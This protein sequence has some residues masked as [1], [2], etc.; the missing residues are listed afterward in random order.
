MSKKTSGGWLESLKTILYAGLI[1]IGIRTVAFEPFNIPSGSM[2][3]TLQ[4]GDYLFVSKYS[5]GYSRASLPFSPNL[6]SG[7]IFGSL[8]ARGD[9][10]VFKL[11]RDGT[12]DYIKR[13]VGLPGDRIQVRQGIL[14]VNGQ[15][16]PRTALGPYTV[17]GDGP[18]LTV[19]LYRETLPPSPGDP[20]RSHEI[21]EASDDGPYDNTPEFVVPANHVFVMGDN[22]DNSLDSRATNYVGFV[23]VENLVG[24]AE[25]IFFSWDGSANWY[26]FWAW[27]F[28]VRWSRIFSG[29]R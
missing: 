14:R 13:I 6:F 4:V 11:P 24:R 7:R 2:I 8:P 19:R 3:P 29:V 26:E 12:T 21:L 20:A 5:Y 23:P 27:P 9:V 18:R 17:E 1:A 10:A 15:P 22:R 25:F 28:A 16:V